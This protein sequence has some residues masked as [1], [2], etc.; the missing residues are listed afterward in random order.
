MTGAATADPDADADADG[1]EALHMPPKILIATG[2]AGEVLEVLYPYRRLQEEGYE[3]HIVAPP[4]GL[5]VR[6]TYAPPQGRSWMS[7]PLPTGT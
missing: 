3:V 1:Q 7:P 2:D 4:A 6:L 5:P